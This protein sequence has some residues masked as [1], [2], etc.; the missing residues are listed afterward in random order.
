[1]RIIHVLKSNKKLWIGTLCGI[2]I[3]TTATV[4]T[5]FAAT[6]DQKMAENVALLDS[7]V[8]SVNVTMRPT[9]LDMENGNLVYDVEF[10][11]G[12][13]KYEYEIDAESGSV[14]EK[15]IDTVKNKQTAAASTI[16]DKTES[17]TSKHNT[18]T[19]KDTTV[20]ENHL[21][22]VEA[23]KKIAFEDAG[24]KENTVNLI[25]NKLDKEDGVQVYDIEFYADNKEYDYEI[26]AVTGAIRDKSIEVRKQDIPASDI[27][28]ES[29]LIGIETAKK[30]ALKDAKVEE[31]NVTITKNKLTKEDGIQVY[32]IEFFT[33]TNEYEYEINAYT[34]EILDK[35]IE[36]HK[37]KPSKKPAESTENT[38]NNNYIGVDKAKEIAIGHAG[39]TVSDVNFSK[40]KLEKE[41]G[42]KVYEI[43]FYV[44]HMEYEYTIDATTGEILEYDA[45]WDD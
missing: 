12:Q 16:S 28:T 7:G 17:T 6:M 30:T 35:S 45:E 20:K 10:V 22:T 4:G 29:Q 21:M 26:D 31:T 32:D 34:G 39:K 5:V 44:S 41:D 14:M 9:T 33:Q 8:T 3:L 24:V 43:E 11:D 23:A 13:T 19:K 37:V 2:G 15:E 18:T 25:K 42:V 1:M 40:A 38:T 27:V 36:Q